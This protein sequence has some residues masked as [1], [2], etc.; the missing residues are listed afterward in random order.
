MLQRSETHSPA[1]PRPQDSQAPVY[2]LAV[3]SPTWSGK[4]SI[5]P[6]LGPSL[7]SMPRQSKG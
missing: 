2:D 1:L 7:C 4:T 5:L 3:F 6:S